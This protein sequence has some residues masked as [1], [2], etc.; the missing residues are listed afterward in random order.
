MT[1]DLDDPDKTL[2]NPLQDDCT[3]HLKPLPS[4]QAHRHRGQL[5]QSAL[6]RRITL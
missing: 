2:P 6:P 1:Q 5:Y 4:T 3:H